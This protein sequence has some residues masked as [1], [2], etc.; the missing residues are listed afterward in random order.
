VGRVYHPIG[1]T[2]PP[3]T[4][5]ISHYTLVVV[6]SKAKEIFPQVQRYKWRGLLEFSNFIDWSEITINFGRW[7]GGRT[8]GQ[9]LDSSNSNH[10]R[11]NLNF[12]SYFLF[13]YFGTCVMNFLV[14]TLICQKKTFQV[15]ENV[16]GN[17]NT[18]R[19]SMGHWSRMSPHDQCS[20][21]NIPIIGP[22]GVNIFV[23]TIHP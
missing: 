13:H 5:W 9:C 14:P 17:N 3:I 20:H 7:K 12:I 18:Y 8:H 2:G 10:S 15:L 1:R 21:Q 4:D 11:T 22:I 23:F 6:Y 16:V 19:L